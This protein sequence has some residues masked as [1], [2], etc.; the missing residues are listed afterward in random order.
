MTIARRLKA[1]LD[2]QEISYELREHPRTESSS[3]TAQAAHVPGASLAKSVVVHR[4]QDYVLV[5]VPSS[6]RIELSAI[7]KELGPDASLA[8]EE[9]IAALFDDCELGAV[10][11]IGAAYG[12]PVLLDDTLVQTDEVYFEGGDHTT[13]VRVSGDSFH[14]L[15]KD[16]RR[17]K[18]SHAA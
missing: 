1:Y 13:L 2:G 9:E 16:E 18:F 12:L 4:G 5:V 17:G 3:R 8:T 14:R 10:P 15:M 7:Q 6:H 11:P